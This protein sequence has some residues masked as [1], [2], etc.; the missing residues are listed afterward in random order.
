MTKRALLA[1]GGL[2]LS[3]GGVSSQPSGSNTVVLGVYPANAYVNASIASGA[4]MCA[5]IATAATALYATNTGGGTIDARGFIGTQACAGSISTGWPNDNNFVVTVL[6]NAVTIRT[7]V[8]QNIPAAVTVIGPTQ[9]VNQTGGAI[10]QVSS[11]SF[12]INSPVVSLGNVAYTTGASLQ[13]ASVHCNPPTG[14]TP[15]GCIGVQNLYGEE[16]TTIS[17]VNV[18]GATD[19]CFDIE[20]S[21]TGGPQNSGAYHNLGCGPATGVALIAGSTC[22]RIGGATSTQNISDYYQISCAGNEGAAQAASLVA[23]DI[24]GQDINLRDSHVESYVTGISIGSKRAASNVRVTNFQCSA[25]AS[26]PMTSCIDVSASNASVGLWLQNIDT[27]A[28]VTNI[29][30]DNLTSGLTVAAGSGP[31]SLYQRGLSNQVFG[32]PGGAWVNSSPTPTSSGGAFTSASSAIQAQLSPGRV[33]QVNGVITITTAGG[34][35]G[36]IQTAMPFVPVG[37]STCT[38]FE[39]NVGTWVIAYLNSG[40]ATLIMYYAAYASPVANGKIF[41]FTCVYQSQ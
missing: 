38:A 1:I 37:D 11:A 9:V 41:K 39:Y 7:A 14:A 36:S 25:S 6:L 27:S 5:K 15:S 10:F 30:K 35:S 3:V 18:Y 16:N 29:I 33:A 40:A 20:S 31:T 32:L 19:T 13:N 21:G 23:F 2:L 34:A 22:M 12:A 8:T 24:N 28:N 17:H 26:Y 4:D